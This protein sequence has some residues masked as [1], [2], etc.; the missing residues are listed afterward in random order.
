MKNPDRRQASSGFEQMSFLPPLDFNP[1]YPNPSTLPSI[2]LARMQK[3]ERLT[4]P[5][6]GLKHWRLAAYIKELKYLGWPIESMDVPCPAGFG[7]GNPIREYW[8]PQWV[9]AAISRKGGE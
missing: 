7:A 3:G 8:L 5:S 6:F 2:A 9:L 4:Q 1:T